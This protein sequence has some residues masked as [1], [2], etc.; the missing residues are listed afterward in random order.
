MRRF[1]NI[2]CSFLLLLS[3]A[4]A[5]TT[6]TSSPEAGTGGTGAG[7]G[8]SVSKLRAAADIAFTKGNTEE[9]IKLWTSVIELEPGNEQNYY[10]RFRCYLKLTKYKEAISDLTSALSI[11][12]GYAE[13]L[14]QRAKLH[15]RLGKCEE[16]EKDYQAL[17]RL[18]PGHKDAAKLHDAVTCTRNIK[19]AEVAYSKNNFARAKELYNSLIDSAEISTTFL[20]RRAW[21]HYKLGDLYDSIADAG[22]ILKV[23]SKNLEALELRGTCYY[24]LGELDMAL[25]HYKQALSLDPEHRGC[26]AGHKLIKKVT[27]AKNAAEEAAKKGNLEAAILHLQEVVTADP[28]HPTQVRGSRKTIALYY[29]RLN[30]HNEARSLAE[31]LLKPNND[32]WELLKILGDIAMEESSFDEAVGRYRRALEVNQGHH[33]LRTLLQKAEAALKQSKQKD[34][35]KILKVARNANA[36]EIKRSY[37]E[38]ALIWH[39]DKHTGEEEKE[40]AAKEFQLIAEAYEIL[41]DDDLRRKYDLGEEVLPNQGGGGGGGHQGFNP[42]GGF[43][44]RQGGGQH[45]Q[46]HFG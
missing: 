19:E 7:G 22:R 24:V 6:S 3:S 38:L 30:K 11:K 45:F 46:F 41:S 21:S 29:A 10:K 33:E 37:R 32:D 4:S 23:D 35:Y 15:L 44:F 25:T 27:K 18:K 16:A 1:P 34:Y 31:E 36:K 43:N 2:L 12:P 26:K 8:V 14:A 13:A 42:F 9:A 5:S 39:P 40:K 28:D 20:L 17:I